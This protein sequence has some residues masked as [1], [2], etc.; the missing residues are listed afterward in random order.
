MI[1]NRFYHMYICKS[2][3]KDRG[4]LIP[5]KN[6]KNNNK[7]YPHPSLTGLTGRESITELQR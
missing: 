4:D 5:D 1:D 7:T 6:N 3:E 2:H